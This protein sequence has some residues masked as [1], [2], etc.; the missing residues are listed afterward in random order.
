MAG[1]T[2]RKPKE[3]ADTGA[4]AKSL[5]EAAPR[6]VRKKSPTDSTGPAKVR[7]GKARVGKAYSSQLCQAKESAPLEVSLSLRDI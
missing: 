4:E 2:T 6:A 1:R 3:T 7:A 5:H